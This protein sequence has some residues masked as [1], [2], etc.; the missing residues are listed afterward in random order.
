MRLGE[1]LNRAAKQEG[2]QSWGQLAAQQDANGPA[3]QILSGLTE[4][5]LVL[6]G[7]RPG[8]GKTLLGL[9]LAL[10]AVKA[11]RPAAFYSLEY[12]KADVA[13]RLQALGAPI[14]VGDAGF[15]LDTSNDICA[16]YIL[17][18]L[19]FVARGCVVVIDYLQLLDQDRAKPSLAAQV[20]ALKFFA[21]SAGLIVVMISQIDRSY[22][23]AVE[24]VPDM[25][26]VR[27]P[28]PVY[29]TLFT[30]AIFLHNGDVHL[31][32]VA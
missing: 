1:A 7:A 30:K 5:D 14:K 17:K 23:P 27:L 28:N 9:E 24:P 19:R 2:F 18:Q 10:E 31:Q 25:L 29:L 16:D 3:G 15:T 22:D 4:G 12:T 20:C 6:L 26:D 32:A 21:K 11:G 8:Q 13:G